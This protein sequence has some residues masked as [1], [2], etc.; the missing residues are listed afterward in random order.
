MSLGS[1]ILYDFRFLKLK[2]RGLPL[3]LKNISHET[4]PSKV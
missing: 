4:L 2:N 3:Q 1:L